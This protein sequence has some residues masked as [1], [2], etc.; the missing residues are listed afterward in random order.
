MTDRHVGRGVEVIV[1]RKWGELEFLRRVGIK[2]NLGNRVN[3]NH[4]KNHRTK[5]NPSREEWR[6]CGSAVD[7]AV[8]V[9][10]LVLACICADRIWANWLRSPRDTIDSPYRT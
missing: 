3:M 5:S 9:C 2:P 6:G 8:A 7:W 4:C 1:L 10:A